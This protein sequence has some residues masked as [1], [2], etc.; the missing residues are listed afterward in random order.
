MDNFKK[1]IKSIF[2]YYGIENISIR[3]FIQVEIV[4]LIISKLNTKVKVK[5]AWS[6][7][8]KYFSELATLEEEKDIKKYIYT[9]RENYL[10]LGKRRRWNELITEYLKCNNDIRF[11]GESVNGYLVR[12][13]VKYEIEREKIY[14][15]E[16][17]YLLINTNITE[18]NVA[19]DIIEYF[20]K[21]KK[22]NKLDYKKYSADVYSIG[23]DPIKKLPQ[24]KEKI[25]TI[26]DTRINWITI[27]NEMG[28]KF[29]YR[30]NIRLKILNSKN[31]LKVKGNIHIVGALGAGKSTFKFT[32]VFKSVKN[33]CCKVGIVEDNVANVIA[34]V[35]ELRK[36]GIN[37]I[38]VI[39]E[40]NEFKHLDNYYKSIKEEYIDDND[41][42]KFLSGSC[43]VKALANDFESPYEVPCNKLK[44][45]DISVTCPYSNKCGKMKRYRAIYSADVL[46]TTPYSLTKGKLKD[47]IDPYKRGIYE[48][49]HDLLD[50]IIV[51]EADGV[52]STLDSELMPHGKLNY[53]D[54]NI[55]NKVKQFRDEILDNN[56]KLRKKDVYSFSKNVSKID[57]IMPSII[58][59]VLEFDKIQRYIQNEILT[60]TEIFNEV[61]TIL[62]KVEGNEKFIDYLF[63]YVNL[64]NI[65]NITEIE[66][67][68]PLNLLFNE[69]ESIHN[70]NGGYPE[71][72]LYKE[73]DNLLEIN[74]VSLPLNKQGKNIDR[75][76]FIEKI[77]FLILLVQLDYLIRIIT[78]EYSKLQY[79][80][81]GTIKYIDGIQMLPKKLMQFVKEPC[82]GTLYGYKFTYNDGI[83]IDIMRYAGVGRSLLENWAYMKEDIGLEGPGVIC[84][85]GTSY[86]PGSAHYNLKKS[87]D[88]LLLSD[89]PEGKIDIKF[90]PTTREKEFLR[91]SGSKLEFKEENLRYLT[92]NIIRDIKFR[93]EKKKKILIVV[94]SYS[95][96]DVVANVLQMEKDLNYAVVGKEENEF[97]KV[98]TKE[99]IEN[100]EII[101]EEADICIVPL[102]IIARGYNI[103]TNKNSVD[104]E[105]N[106]Y[107][108]SAFF[109]IRPYMVPG[110]FKSYIPIL[111]YK[112]NEIIDGIT[113]KYEDYSERLELFSKLCFAEYN[114]IVSI[115]QWKKLSEEDR[116]MMSWFM[117]VPIKQ[118]I[119]RMQRNGN[120]CEAVFCDLAYCEAIVESKKQNAKNSIFYAWHELLEKNLNDEVI[121]SLFGNFNNS[122]KNLIDDI[123]NTYIDVINDDYYDE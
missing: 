27:F 121:N 77:E 106:S 78:K 109:L 63:Q 103:L 24:Y 16:L 88:I 18:K 7:L 120:S 108:S 75:K 28:G 69:I 19:E 55:I 95:D 25:R 65:D 47:F 33:D 36:L 110:D 114:N 51:D 81:T 92:K 30:P 112:M 82:I 34:T 104:G 96:C 111:H 68:H 21:L 11:Y 22:Q 43:I 87:P 15:D 52:Q 44:E 70:T 113:E 115:G 26:I 72:K 71:T 83:K 116:E 119:G 8:T 79:K 2:N 118:A 38:P 42:M 59:I 39:G 76:T 1:K 48:L 67:N 89:K 107:F 41:I 31:K 58:R 80:Y 49:F 50:F 56:L 4:L 64:I 66:L 60:P 100:F 14:C 40:S 61:K 6:V 99:N 98:I 20:S 91:I 94:N 46:V 62:E 105:Y 85:S 54:D 5:D 13:E 123:N 86:S 84:L 37:A 73:I 122:L 9:A 101:T 57:S 12:N 29:K 53:G 3:E 17:E 35:I 45:D 23:G 102:S 117:L 74:K 97:S 93:I 10:N 32:Y 90:L